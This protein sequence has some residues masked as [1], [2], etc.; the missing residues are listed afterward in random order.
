M[1]R[2]HGCSAVQDLVP[3]FSFQARNGPWS[4][5]DPF[6]FAV[7]EN[8]IF[9]KYNFKKSIT[10]KQNR[11]RMNRDLCRGFGAGPRSS[12]S[13]GPLELSGSLV[14]IASCSGKFDL[15]P[16]GWPHFSGKGWA[17]PA[18]WRGVP[19]AA[20]TCTSSRPAG[21]ASP[22][23][24]RDGGGHCSRRCCRPY[25]CASP[26]K[27]AGLPGGISS[28]P[29]YVP[30]RFLI[31]NLNAAIWRQNLSDRCNWRTII[32]LLRGEI[33]I[34]AASSASNFAFAKGECCWKRS[35]KFLQQSPLGIPKNSGPDNFPSKR[36]PHDLP[37]DCPVCSVFLHGQFWQS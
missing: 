37:C 1:K 20:W 9:L 18:S 30:A 34:P 36:L 3:L 24:R 14:S 26:H 7:L 11:H 2:L 19:S 5:R 28:I 33:R 6:S 25:W 15:S 12:S 27:L 29:G 10:S 16:T 17:G 23:S 35:W 32:S 13:E 21:E 8:N 31:S 4:P 22:G